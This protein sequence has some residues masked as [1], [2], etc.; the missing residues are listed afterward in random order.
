MVLVFMKNSHFLK[1]G[2]F[3]LHLIHE[4]TGLRRGPYLLFNEK[5]IFRKS[6]CPAS[7]PFIKCPKVIFS[8]QLKLICLKAKSH[9]NKTEKQGFPSLTASCVESIKIMYLLSAIAGFPYKTRFDKIFNI[10]VI[11]CLF[12][13]SQL[14]VYLNLT[15]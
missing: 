2:N 8:L 6:C 13:L 4:G 10:S 9:N 3:C 12:T 5:F 14:F 1:C 7:L 11:S 15:R